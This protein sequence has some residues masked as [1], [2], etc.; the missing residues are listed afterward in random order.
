[1]FWHKRFYCTAPLNGF[2]SKGAIVNILYYY[3]L[4]LLL[5][6][7]SIIII[8]YKMYIAPYI[9]QSCKPNK[10]LTEKELFTLE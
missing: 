8:I 10:K 1:M 4:L 2:A 6:P 9:I 7:W 3:Y 5:I